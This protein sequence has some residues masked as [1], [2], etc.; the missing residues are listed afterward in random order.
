MLNIDQTVNGKK[1]YAKALSSFS[2]CSS[3]CGDVDM[4]LQ[5][6]LDTL[7]E[8]LEPGQYFII[9][10]DELNPDSRLIATRGMTKSRYR[11]IIQHVDT[12]D[13]PPENLHQK[14]DTA[15]EKF[16]RDFGFHVIPF[17]NSLRD[18]NQ[19][20]VFIGCCNHHL[21]FSKN[22]ISF[23]KTLISILELS[24]QNQNLKQHSYSEIQRIIDA[25]Q[26]WESTVDI[27]DVLIC[28]LNE[29]G[30]VYRV[31]KTLEKWNLGSVRC[32]KETDPHELLHHDCHDS[33]CALNL[34]WL[35]LWN[36]STRSKVETRE[37]SDHI[38]QRDL[39]MTMLRGENAVNDK[40]SDD[41]VTLIIED[42][43][44]SR[45]A[46][47]QLEEHGKKLHAQILSQT[48]EID[49]I[50]ANLQN[51]IDQ[52]RD[53]RQSLQLTEK[54][55]KSLS[56][57]LITAQEEER[58][59]IAAELHDGVGQTISAI[60][61]NLE[62]FLTIKWTENEE[63]NQK[64]H[65]QK[66]IGRLRDAV[67][68][69]RR[70]SMGLRP[71]MIDELG[72]SITIQWLC[73]GFQKDFPAIKIEQELHLDEEDI[74]EIQKVSIFRI[75]QEALNNIA[76]YSQ[77]DKVCIE[78]T[79]AQNIISLSIEDNGIGF[80]LDAGQ[81]SSG[82]GLLSMKE[83]ASLSEGNL[84][85]HSSPGNGTLIKSIWEVSPPYCSLSH[86]R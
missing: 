73:R 23:L 40:Q 15:P 12:W 25:K 77:A 56:A 1:N 79:T 13:Q 65:L 49:K 76:K 34:N 41:F 82:F 69:I 58:K 64:K 75:V 33:N 67:E 71:P 42:I 35:S 61:F 6:F 63:K 53:V 78:L 50:N 11:E 2:G 72:L 27:L 24:L 7:F 18:G 3:R 44:E 60:K 46:L 29:H 32:I 22:D 10:F 16:A 66:V 17:I 37:F 20:T 81:L 51:K 26:Q 62:G 54:K 4:I 14:L 52:N 80:Q 19:T 74:S 59:R 31:N 84:S 83:R 68:E 9:R 28:M 86:K 55:I 45:L 48:I 8:T 5:R 57:R 36:S 21:H 38:L 30:K 85:I 39:R 43:S 47:K 70:I